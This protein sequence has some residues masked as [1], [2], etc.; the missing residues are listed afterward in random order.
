[1]TEDAGGRNVKIDLLDA[2][3]VDEMPEKYK[4]EDYP[5]ILTQIRGQRSVK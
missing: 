2:I 1:V 5:R 4:T 3:P